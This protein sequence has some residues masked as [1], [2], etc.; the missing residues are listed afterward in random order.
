MM[1]ER[2]SQAAEKEISRAGSSFI[3]ALCQELAL[4]A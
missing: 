4:D 2:V 3:S 1:D